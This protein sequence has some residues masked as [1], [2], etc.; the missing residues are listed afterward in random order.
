MKR[1]TILTGTVSAV[2]AAKT[3]AISAS[4]EAPLCALDND[5]PSNC[6]EVRARRRSR[7]RSPRV[8]LFVLGACQ[9]ALAEID[10]LDLPLS[11]VAY[12]DDSIPGRSF[13]DF[14]AE[15]WK[16][17]RKRISKIDNAMQFANRAIDANDRV[18]LIGNFSAPFASNMLVSLATMARDM[19]RPMVVIGG[20]PAP[21]AQGEIRTQ[22]GW[23][24]IDALQRIGCCV[25]TSPLVFGAIT[26]GRRSSTGVGVVG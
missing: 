15:C 26:S 11:S 18:V 1:R 7:E 13:G 23:T 20:A 22:R 17:D 25:T 3:P 24:C 10:T 9:H 16:V 6:W 8:A 19:N 2:I 4:G 14:T 5:P 12:L 21:G